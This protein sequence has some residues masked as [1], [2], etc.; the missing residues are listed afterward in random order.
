MLCSL[1]PQFEKAPLTVPECALCRLGALEAGRAW[2]RRGEIR[3]FYFRELLRD[4]MCCVV[5]PSST[6]S[7]SLS[8]L[9][10]FLAHPYTRT[11]NV[12]EMGL[13]RKLCHAH[14][15]ERWT[16]MYK[17]DIIVLCTEGLRKV[18]DQ[19]TTNNQ[20]QCEFWYDQLVN[21]RWRGVPRE[22]YVGSVTSVV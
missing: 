20:T 17:R 8:F 5:T 16:N 21:L 12:G 7:L 10:V 6:L 2:P 3:V 13:Y 4:R 14:L 9:S 11:L 19:R 15:S 18:P 22:K 1:S